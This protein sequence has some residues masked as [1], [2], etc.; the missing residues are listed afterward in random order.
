MHYNKTKKSKT[1]SITF[2]EY[3]S[4][5]HNY[6]GRAR[7][8]SQRCQR[9]EAR[10]TRALDA[11]RGYLWCPL[12]ILHPL[13]QPQSATIACTGRFPGV[14]AANRHLETDLRRAPY[15]HLD[16]QSMQTPALD[17]LRGFLWCPLM[18]LHPL[19]QPRSATIACTGRFPGVNAAI[20][21]L[22]TDL[23]TA[24]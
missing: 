3:K 23:R 1:N 9:L 7:T 18:I 22:E 4:A 11:L 10:L 13:M 19:M 2:Q 16:H 12:M 20:R 6:C 8:A 21:H 15:Q 14:N 17:A 5:K 24:F